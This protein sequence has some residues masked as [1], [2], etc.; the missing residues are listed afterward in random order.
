MAYRFVKLPAL[1]GEVPVDDVDGDDI[2]EP[3]QLTRDEGAVGPGAG[4]R[5][6]QVI[7]AG[8]RLV[9]RRARCKPQRTLNSGLTT[10]IEKGAPPRNS[11]L[12]PCPFR[13]SK[14]APYRLPP[15]L[16]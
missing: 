5:H 1:V 14:L 2:L 10:P 4:E 8:G 11:S 6:V 15:F 16:G 13:V 12:A 7:A 9:V 3:L